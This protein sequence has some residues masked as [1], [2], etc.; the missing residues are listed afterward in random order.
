MKPLHHH[1][2]FCLV[3]AVLCNRQD[4]LGGELCVQAG[5]WRRLTNDDWVR[6]Y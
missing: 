1:R 2:D 6:K 5:G 4:W 3:L